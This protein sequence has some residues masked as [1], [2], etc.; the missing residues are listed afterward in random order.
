MSAAPET[1]PRPSLAGRPVRLPDGTKGR[2]EAHW[3]DPQDPSCI[4]SRDDGRPAVILRAGALGVLDQPSDPAPSAPAPHGRRAPP[5][6]RQH[7]TQIG[8]A[9]V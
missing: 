4:V 2:I 7:W 3:G 9:H 5:P 6:R 8:R 1:V